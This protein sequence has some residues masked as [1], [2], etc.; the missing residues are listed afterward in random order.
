MI[1]ALGG[2]KRGYDVRVFSDV[3]V[4]RREA[5]RSLVLDRLAHHGVLATTIGQALLE[6][7]VSLDDPAVS[8]R[9]QQLLA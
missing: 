3:T 5:D 7:S 9:I 8:A 1:A 4:A 2:A 6:W